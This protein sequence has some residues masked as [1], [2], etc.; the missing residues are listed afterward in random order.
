MRQAVMQATEG[1]FVPGP[2]ELRPPPVAIKRPL[3][4]RIALAE[5]SSRFSRSL[6]KPRTSS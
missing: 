1:T 5:G 3:P 6:K 2:H 4:A